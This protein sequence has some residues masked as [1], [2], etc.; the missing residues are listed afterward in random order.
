MYNTAG[1]AVAFFLEIGENDFPDLRNQHVAMLKT[2]ESEAG[3]SKR[4]NGG[5]TITSKSASTTATWGT[6]G[7]AK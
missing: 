6:R 7:R 2:P 4:W 3:R 1:N 5:D